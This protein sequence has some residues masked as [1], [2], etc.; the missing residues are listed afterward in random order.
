MNKIPTQ[1]VAELSIA[2]SAVAEKN[3]PHLEYSEL[4]PQ[5]QPLPKK[6][7][8]IKVDRSKLVFRAP[9]ST[10]ASTSTALKKTLFSAVDGGKAKIAE[11]LLD[12][13]VSPDTGTDANAVMRA[14]YNRNTPSLQLL[15]EFGANPDI[16]DNSGDTPLRIACDRREE[17]AKLLLEYGADPNISAPD[18]TALPWALNTKEESIVELLLQYGADPNLRSKNGETGLLYACD[19]DVSPNIVQTIMNWGGDPNQENAHGRSPLDAAT[20]HNKSQV[21]KILLDHGA[22]PVLSKSAIERLVSFKEPDCLPLLLAAGLDLSIFPGI[23]EKAVWHESLKACEHL[24]DARVDPNQKL[25]DRY[26]PLTTSIRENRREIF[27]YL[28]KHGADPN[29]KGED[30]PLLVAA[31]RAHSAPYVQRLIEA[32]ADPSK[33]DSSPMVSASYHNN[34]EGV[35][36]F[37]AA[38]L[39][40]NVPNRDKM[41]PLTEALRYNHTAI[42]SFFTVRWC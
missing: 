30:W 37:H 21:V 28:L 17:Q 12:R 3:V 16:G 25:D 2:D 26:S 35:K 22:K 8:P 5:L 14:T 18:W 29:A 41:T 20:H 23:M 39:P 36:A 15:L 9:K 24:V 19:R 27:E 7:I 33:C 34:L 13:G 1:S 4:E 38:G 10:S 31:R 42:V 11:Q 40:L 6:Y 32:G